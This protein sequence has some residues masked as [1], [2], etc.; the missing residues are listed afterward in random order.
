[1]S[2]RVN[3]INVTWLSDERRNF[4]NMYWENK[5]Y[6][7]LCGE[8]LKEDGNPSG[9]TFVVEEGNQWLP[10]E[11]RFW[12]KDA[13]THV[14]EINRILSEWG[15]TLDEEKEIEFNKLN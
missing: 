14:D 10:S 11:A 4:E 15:L 13:S 1:M 3:S 7:Q 12:E 9:K 8:F 6:Y 5:V 2:Y